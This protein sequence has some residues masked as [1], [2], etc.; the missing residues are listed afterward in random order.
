METGGF[1]NSRS[2]QGHN[3]SVKSHGIPLAATSFEGLRGR[4]YAGMEGV[5]VV[6]GPVGYQQFLGQLGAGGEFAGGLVDEDLFASGGGERVVLGF[7]MLVA[8]GDPPVTDAHARE[9]IA[10]PRQVDVGAYTAIVTDSV[11]S[12]LRERI[13]PQRVS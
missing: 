4:R 9:C 7:G 8:G 6:F 10:N 2:T 1:A 11:D 5:P 12:D 3:P 13:G